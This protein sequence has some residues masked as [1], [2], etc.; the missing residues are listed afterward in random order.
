MPSVLNP[1]LCL[2]IKVYFIVLEVMDGISNNFP[3]SSIRANLKDCPGSFVEPVIN[4]PQFFHVLKLK[5]KT[6]VPLAFP[7]KFWWI[8]RG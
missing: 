1:L 6:T 8:A 3:L 7:E 4:E 2:K 5:T